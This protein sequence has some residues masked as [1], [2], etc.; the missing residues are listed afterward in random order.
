MDCF[1]IEGGRALHGTVRAAGSKNAALPLL[2]ATLLPVGSSR[3]RGVPQLRDL[4]SM[5]DLLVDLGATASQ[6]E[7]GVWEI[8]CPTE[9]PTEAPYEVVRKMRASV[10]VLGP[11]LAR[12]GRARVSLPGGCVIGV[13]PIDLH[14]KGLAALGAEI[15]V[16]HGT[17]VAEAP[18]GGLRGGQVYLASRWG[19]TVLG[20]ANVMLA[21]VLARGTTV[22]DAAAQEPEILALADFLNSCGAQVYGAGGPRIVIDGVDELKGVDAWVPADRIEVG[23]LLLAGAA[24]CGDVTVE[25]CAPEEL[26]V[27]LDLFTQSGVPFEAGEGHL[28]VM[29]WTDRPRAL[30]ISCRPY[31]GLPTDLQAQWMAFCTQAEGLAMITDTVYPDRF[32]HVAELN[33]LGA[34]IRREGGTALVVG[35]T[36]L[37]G[38]PVLASDLRASAA[39]VIAG[40]VAEGVTEVRRVYHLDRGYERLEDKL[41]LLGG[42]VRRELD[43]SGA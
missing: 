9:G 28:R 36:Q 41:E 11:L 31:P 21:A 29:P 3:L 18:P 15:R 13:R 20:T 5:R 24:T 23:T 2:A 25:G 14:L 39:L 22:I 35:P 17:V 33:R 6:A 7:E 16:E 43:E 27:L 34:H 8:S 1:R 38:A 37:S 26:T 42:V 30:D 10:A 40:L 32:M 12:R 4:L 19:S